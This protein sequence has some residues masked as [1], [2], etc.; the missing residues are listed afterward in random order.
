M[1][2]EKRCLRCSEQEIVVNRMGRCQKEEGADRTREGGDAV[3][4]SQSCPYGA[5]GC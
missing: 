4:G 3:G 2:G 1:T 5:T